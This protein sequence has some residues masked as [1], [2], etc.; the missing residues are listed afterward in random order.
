MDGAL[1]SYYWDYVFGRGKA[2]LPHLH[3]SLDLTYRC[4]LRCNMCFLYGD[5]LGADNE[6]LET[7]HRRREL[8]VEDW[9]RCLDEL[10]ALG[11]KSLVMSGGEVFLKVGF[12]E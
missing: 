12:I 8:A 10:Q 1:L 9:R 3:V 2:Q 5:H 7:V 4:N 11:V 6:R